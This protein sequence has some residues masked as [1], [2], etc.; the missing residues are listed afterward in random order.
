MVSMSRPPRLTILALTI[1][2]FQMI[3]EI[4]ENM[5]SRA[6]YIISIPIYNFLIALKSREVTI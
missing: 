5:T 2:L 4:I 3:Q 1:Y 6:N